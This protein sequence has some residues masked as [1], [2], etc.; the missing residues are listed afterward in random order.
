LRI[1]GSGAALLETGKGEKDMSQ[2]FIKCLIMFH[3]TRKKIYLMLTVLAAATL[4]F[5]FLKKEE[6]A[7]DSFKALLAIFFYGIC[8]TVSCLLFRRSRPKFRVYYS[9]SLRRQSG[10]AR[11]ITDYLSPALWV[12]N[13]DYYDFREGRQLNYLN[14]N[15]VC[16]EINRNLAASDLFVRFIND[17]LAPNKIYSLNPGGI[18]S[19]TGY[20]PFAR[21]FDYAKYEVDVSYDNFGFTA[22]YNRFQIVPLEIQ[23][24]PMPH[25]ATIWFTEVEPALDLALQITRRFVA[26]YTEHRNQRRRELLLRCYENKY[27]QGDP[28]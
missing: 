27:N 11:F 7:E 4:V 12:H 28:K 5:W 19:N 22:P 25:I 13:I 15:A 9:Y 14:A 20:N 17:E 3:A 6:Y 16:A 1:N 18:F 10:L 2:F 8:M 21:Q 24:G 26:G 23:T